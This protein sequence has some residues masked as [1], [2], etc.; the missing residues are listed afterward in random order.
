MTKSTLHLLIFLLFTANL[1]ARQAEWKPV[2]GKIMTSWAAQVS[3]DNPLSEYPRPQLQRQNNWQNLNGLWQYA[4]RPR[5][6]TSVP[7]T[8]DGKILVPYPIESAL[9]GVGKTVGKDKYLWYKTSIGVSSKFRNKNLLLHFG[10]IDWA[11]VVYVNGQKAGEHSGGYDPFTFDISSYL[12]KAK[13][14]EIVIRV[15]DPTEDGF[16]PAGK[17]R[18]KPTGIW[19]TSVTGIW[20][21]VW[22]EAVA[23]T[24]IAKTIQTPDIDKEILNVKVVA[25][26]AQPADQVLISAW[27]GGKKV[28]EIKTSPGAEGVLPVPHAKLWSPDTPFLYDLKVQVL[29]SGKVIDEISSYFAMRK[30]SMA[31]DQN[32]IQRMMLNNSFVFQ[33]GTLDQGWWPDGLYTAPTD[34]ALRYD[35]EKTKEM[36]FNMIRK[37]IKVEPARWYYHCDQLGMLVWQDMPSGDMEGFEW[38]QRLGQ[39]GGRPLDKQRSPQSEQAYRQEWERIMDALHNFPSIIVWVPFNESWGQ[40]KSMEIINWTMDHDRSRLVN[41]ASGGNYF[42]AGHIADLHNYPDPLM[43]N[44]VVFG[45]KQILVLGEFGGLGW[46][47]DG[48]SWLDKGNFGYQSFKNAR[49]LKDRYAGLVTDLNRLIPLGLSAAVYT[50]ITD[51]EIEVNGLMTYDRKVVKI[52]VDQLKKIHHVL[53]NAVK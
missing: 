27:D 52:P 20:Q 7:K 16:Q 43:P 51:V 50:Q 10:A 4:I 42:P 5:E 18:K 26:H 25:E 11:C 29:R 31:K 21:T 2:A 15:F 22:L 24:Y 32:G 35:I 45:D 41:G 40:F 17:Q 36:G 19:Y 14:Q 1:F 39:I 9:S 49:E 47:V 28:S 37:H 53:F 8:F 44:P 12:R 34:S 33:Y 3:P 13:K 23:G 46:A 48:H 6:E 38:E 30:I